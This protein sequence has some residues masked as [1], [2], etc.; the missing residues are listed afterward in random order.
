MTKHLPVEGASLFKTK[1]SAEHL[2]KTKSV[3]ST[4]TT[5]EGL[6]LCKVLMMPDSGVALVKW[7]TYGNWIKSP[8]SSLVGKSGSVPCVGRCSELSPC[9]H[10]NLGMGFLMQGSEPASASLLCGPTPKAGDASRPSSC[11]LC[12]QCQWGWKVETGKFSLQTLRFCSPLPVNICMN[13][14]WSGG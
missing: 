14:S 4:C 12:E 3:H 13:H 8:E 6:C 10:S 1:P 5:M 2:S 9:F 11:F 7:V